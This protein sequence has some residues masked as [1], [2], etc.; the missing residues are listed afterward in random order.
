MI[1]FREA[2]RADLPAIV[3]MLAQDTLGQLRKKY[4]EPLLRVY[5]EGFERI[6]ADPNQ[7]LMVMESPELGIIGTMQLS[8]IQYLT[9]QGGIRAQIE[10]V[11]IREDQRAKGWG[12]QLFEWAIRRA[13]EREAHLLQL[14]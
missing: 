8:F 12:K 2:H 5:Y 10:A 14:T 4:H 11:R 9:Y 13:Q 6:K 7:E 3:R 1:F